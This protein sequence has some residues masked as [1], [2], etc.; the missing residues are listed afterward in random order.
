VK[1]PVDWDQPGADEAR[2]FYR[3]VIDLSR[4]HPGLTDGGLEILPTDAEQDVIAYR[5]GDVVVLVNTRATPVRVTPADVAVEGARDLLG[6]GVR[7]GDVVALPAYGAVAL[8]LASS[9]G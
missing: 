1:E 2:S 4:T 3:H 7:T 5:R 6:G 8:E 9:G